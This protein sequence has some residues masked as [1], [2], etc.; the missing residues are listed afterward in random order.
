MASG[1][2][3][4]NLLSLPRNQAVLREGSCCVFRTAVVYRCIVLVQL[5][6]GPWQLEGARAAMR[7]QAE[8]EVA[9]EVGH[10]LQMPQK[11]LCSVAVIA[12]ESRKRWRSFDWSESPAAGRHCCAAC[13]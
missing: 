6:D 12:P 5:W 2:Y 10:A 13:A 7:C 4:Q 3:H 8:V 9:A 1:C 11:G